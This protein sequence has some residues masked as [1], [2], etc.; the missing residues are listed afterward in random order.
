MVLSEHQQLRFSDMNTE[1]YP[2]DQFSYHV[3]HMIKNGLI[4][5]VDD[6]NY[7]LTRSGRRHLL[8]FDSKVD[9]YMEQGLIGIRAIITRET[10]QGEEILIQ[11]RYRE[12]HL[13]QFVLPG[14]RVRFGEPVHEAVQRVVYSENGISGTYQLLGVRHIIEE[15]E[16]D[17]LQDKYF[18]VFK[19]TSITG[20]LELSGPTGTNQWILMSDLEKDDNLLHGLL[21]LTAMRNGTP[22]FFEEMQNLQS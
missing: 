21:D 6:K 1:G 17:A 12:P 10:K 18:F 3:R 9:A 14:G 16:R 15:T 7:S 22:E 8:T 20:N 11:R 13:G 2:S 4:E 19:A 5:K